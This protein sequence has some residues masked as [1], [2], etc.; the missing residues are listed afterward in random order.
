M[1]PY[2]NVRVACGTWRAPEGADGFWA[3]PMALARL[4]RERWV[5]QSVGS[6]TYREGGVEGDYLDVIRRVRPRLLYE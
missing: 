1:E 3:Q 5:M 6:I 2:G 4:T